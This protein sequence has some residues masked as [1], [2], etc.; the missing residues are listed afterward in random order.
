M[1]RITFCEQDGF[2][3]GFILRGHSGFAAAGSDIVCAAVTSCALMTANT[4]T[5]VC[6]LPANAEA[7]DGLIR[8]QLRKD[9]AAKVEQLLEGF[10]L[11]I[12]E[13]SKAYP[14]NINCQIQK[15]SITFRRCNNNAE[16]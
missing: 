12:R 9:D 16:N 15:S 14:Q 13:L 8:L 2:L 5:E 6:H 3:T 10:R 4:V 1:I 11:H 7:T